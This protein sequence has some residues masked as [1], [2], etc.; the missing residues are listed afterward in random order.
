VPI[1][2]VIILAALGSYIFSLIAGF[3]IGHVTVGFTFVLFAL[4]IG[5][6][7]RLIRKKSQLTTCISLSILAGI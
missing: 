7:F 3:P 5:Y 2:S 4:A 6:F 1:F